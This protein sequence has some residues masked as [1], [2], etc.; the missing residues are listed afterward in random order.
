M[1]FVNNNQILP[2]IDKVFNLD[3]INNAYKYIEERNQKG[4]IVISIND[5]SNTL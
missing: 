5:K 2:S 1:E 4:K 3:R